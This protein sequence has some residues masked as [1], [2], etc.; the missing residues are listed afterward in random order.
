MLPRAR[1]LKSPIL[2]PKRDNELFT[3]VCRFIILRADVSTPMQA[4]DLEYNYIS[5][6][7]AYVDNLYYGKVAVFSVVE[8]ASGRLGDLRHQ[9]GFWP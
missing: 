3:C 5:R 8:T 6:P 2:A 7:M 9:L 4:I 1:T